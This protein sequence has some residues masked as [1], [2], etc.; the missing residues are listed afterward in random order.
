MPRKKATAARQT[1][2]QVGD[3][4]SISGSVNI[5]G[6][7]ISTRQVNPGLSPGEI[8]QLFSRIYASIDANPHTSPTAR[9]DVKEEVQEIQAA[10]GAVVEGK[11]KLEEGFLARRFRNIARVA[12]DALEVIVAALANPLAGLGIAIKKIAEKAKEETA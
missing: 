7:N 6:G 9:N 5:A 11:N 10:V 1:T 4:S 8:E 3:I 2:I 12:P